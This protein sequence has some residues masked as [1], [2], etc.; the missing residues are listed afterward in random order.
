MSGCPTDEASGSEARPAEPALADP[1][2]AL[3]VMC[4]AQRFD[5]ETRYRIAQTGRGRRLLMTVDPAATAEPWEHLF[6]TTPRTDDIVDL[7]G[8]RRARQETL[9][10]SPAT[11][12]PPEYQGGPAASAGTRVSSSRTT[13]PTWT[14]AFRGWPRNIKPGN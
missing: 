2:A 12:L 5:P 3:V 11:G 6:L 13:P 9:V 10:R 14:S 7:P 1:S 4:E 8:Q